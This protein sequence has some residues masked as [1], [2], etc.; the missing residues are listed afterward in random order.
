[1]LRISALLILPAIFLAASRSHTQPFA[2]DAT[3]Q[4]DPV[5]RSSSRTDRFY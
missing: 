3:T 2:P 5:D 4:I 1:M